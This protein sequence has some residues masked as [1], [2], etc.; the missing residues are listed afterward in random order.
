VAFDLPIS[1]KRDPAEGASSSGEPAVLKS[2]TT[3]AL[4]GLFDASALE[5][6]LA[7]LKTL[8]PA[9]SSS[10]VVEMQDVQVEEL[11]FVRDLASELMKL[12]AT[13]LNV[14]VL[15]R[16]A[17]L[18]ESM[19]QIAGSRDWLIAWTESD[20]AVGRRSIHLDRGFE[21]P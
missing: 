16:E 14:Q 12:R 18:H 9:P 17:K 1:A 5:E 8:D 3:I 4:N 10:V 21:K 6:V 15:V 7:K 11:Q 20:V 13:G 19:Q 2:S